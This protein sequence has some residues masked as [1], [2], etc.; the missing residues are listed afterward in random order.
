M[1]KKDYY[2]IMGLDKNASQSDIKSSYRKLARKYHPDLNKSSSAETKFK[3]VGEA[4]DVLKDK[5]KRAAYD[6]YGEH[7]QNPHQGFGQGSQHHQQQG[8]PFGQDQGGDFDDILS[9]LFGQ[10]GRR[11]RKPQS[12]K[13]QDIN[14]KLSISIEDSFNGAEKV[15]K[16]QVPAK[17]GAQTTTKTIKVKI[18]KGITNLQKIR[19][20]G[21]GGEGFNSAA[22][23]LYIEVNINSHPLY[24][25][26]DSDLYLDL[27]ITPSE[28]ALGAIIAV[29]TLTGE[30]NLKIP[31]GSASGTKLRLK[32][33]GLPSKIPG[34]LYVVISIV[35]VPA[36]TD[37]IKELYKKLADSTD[38]NPREKWGSNQ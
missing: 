24:K 27:P 4:Y 37:D 12:E 18:P 19:L 13:G 23:D 38:F 14:T 32:N 8:S 9:S 10:S 7:W 22:G 2:K 20:K 21:Q 33:K 31:A 30:I 17:G 5:E 36:N 29:P 25:L 3:E 16:L 28:A 35:V 1:S 15:F 11:A 6:Q 34:Y 26:Q